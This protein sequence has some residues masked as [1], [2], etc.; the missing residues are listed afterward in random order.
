LGQLISIEKE[1]TVKP[2]NKVFLLSIP[3]T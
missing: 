3:N 2:R 1:W